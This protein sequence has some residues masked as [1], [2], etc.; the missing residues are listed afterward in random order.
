MDAFSSDSVP[1]HL[2]TLEA[3]ELY[4]QHLKPNGVLVVHISNLNLDLSPLVF[5][6][7]AELGM[8]AVRIANLA[9]S[10]RLQSSAEWM[11]LSRDAAYIE[12]FPPG[13]ERV[14]AILK[15]KP[16]ALTVTYPEE[17][18]LT[19]A[20]LWTD[21]YSDLFSVLKIPN[22]KRL[23]ASSKPATGDGG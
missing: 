9:F 7:A 17:L 19:D 15:L 13:A 1:V 3:M 10:R 23:W 5:R 22:W 16:K 2:I 21:D 12:S 4:V 8:R 18:N 14:R 6:L 11:I 20:P